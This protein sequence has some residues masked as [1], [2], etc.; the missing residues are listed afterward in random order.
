MRL[1]ITADLL[2]QIHQHGEKAYPSEGAGFLLG[3]SGENMRVVTAILK[4]SNARE[5]SAQHNRYLLTPQDMLRSEQ[6]AA[7]LGLDVIGVF[8]SH[9]DHPNQPSEFDR[10][11]A[12]PWFS[13]IITS[14]NQGTAAG[15]R[16]WRL[17]DDRAQF[18]EEN[19]QIIQ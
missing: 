9:P 7:R 11:W 10:E 16:S 6:E 3:E 1:E 2:K 4:L 8:H 15:S 12:M 18:V 14:V 5:E 19:I 17:S 13:Y